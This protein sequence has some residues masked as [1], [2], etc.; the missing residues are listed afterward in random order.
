MILNRYKITVK[1]RQN[2]RLPGYL[3]SLLRGIWGETLHQ[4]HF[5]AY[6]YLFKH[7]LN[8]AHPFFNFLGKNP[9]V[10]YW[11]YAP[12][13]LREIRKNETFHFYFTM[14]KNPFLN[15]QN[16]TLLFQRAFDRP[17]YNGFFAGEMIS[18][19]PAGFKENSPE[20]PLI[21][22]KNLIPSAGR[23]K[24]KFPVP[25]SLMRKNSLFLP[26]IRRI[27]FSFWPTGPS[28][29]NVKRNC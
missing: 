26:P 6:N 22:F 21:D 19:E 13:K 14:L 8:P 11:F 27:F 29:S 24:V 1:A 17:V 23:I 18:I 9:P 2:G 25:V 7:Q 12:L 20:I 28:C 10:P 3:G 16:L 15:T 4:Y 5:L